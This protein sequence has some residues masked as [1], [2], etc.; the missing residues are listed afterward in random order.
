[1]NAEFSSNQERLTSRQRQIAELI[2]CGLSNAEIAA[3]LGIKK[4]TVRSQSKQFHRRT[5]Q[6]LRKLALAA[7]VSSGGCSGRTRGDAG[8]RPTRIVRSAPRDK[9]ESED[10]VAHLTAGGNHSNLK[11]PAAS[12]EFKKLSPRE[13]QV[14][15]LFAESKLGK[16]IANELAIQPNTEKTYRQRIFRKLGV[17]TMADA[18]QI[19]RLAR[20]VTKE[21]PRIATKRD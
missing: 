10:Q 2:A 6:T 5:G 11:R 17:N 1:M 20:S 9:S 3:R 16:E 8:S 4:T 15:N 7:A 12:T 21:K 18:L 19:V 14:L 13:H